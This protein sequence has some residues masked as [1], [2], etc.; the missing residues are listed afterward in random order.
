ME[1][2]RLFAVV[3]SVRFEKNL[4]YENL[5]ARSAIDGSAIE[6]SKENFLLAVP[7]VA[8]AVDLASLRMA[9]AEHA[10][11]HAADEPYPH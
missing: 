8:A 9:S 4:K 6:G 10:V 7:V 1:L 2:L 3:E 11:R 5:L